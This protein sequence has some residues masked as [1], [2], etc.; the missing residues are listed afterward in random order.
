M[1]GEREEQWEKVREQIE[2][3]ICLELLKDPKTLPCLHTYCKECLKKSVTIVQDKTIINC[4]ACRKEITL[5]DKGVE[6]LPTNFTLASLVEVV[7]LHEKVTQSADDIKCGSCSNTSNS[8]VVAFCY[9]CREF[10]CQ[11]CNRSHKNMKTL[12]HHNCVSVEELKSLKSSGSLEKPEFCK[13]HPEKKVKLYC[14]ACQLL[15]CKDCALV[16]HKDHTYD[17][18]NTVADNERKDLTAA[19]YSLEVKLKTVSDKITVVSEERNRLL[20]RSESDAAKL[21]DS[22]E[23]AITLLTVR[24]EALDADIKRDCLAVVEPVEVYEQ[25]LKDTEVQMKECVKFGQELVKQPSNQEMLGMKLQVME[26]IT[27]LNASYQKFLHDQPFPQ[28][29]PLEIRNLKLP[30]KDVI[31]KFCSSYGEFKILNN[32]DNCLLNGLGIVRAYKSKEAYFSITLKNSED[33]RLT[34]YPV[35]HIVIQLSC[36]TDNSVIDCQVTD[37]KDGLFN[38][39]YTPVNTGKHQIM[40]TIEGN[41]FP[42]SPFEVNVLPPYA[43]IG[44]KCREV[45]EFGEGRKFGELCRVAVSSS[46]DIAVSDSTNKCII[47]LN[48]AYHFKCVISGKDENQLRYPL[49][50]VYT[51]KDTLLVVDGYYSKIKEFETGGELLSSFGSRGS[52]DGQLVKPSGIAIDKNNRVYIVDR[53]NSRV[54][55]FADGMFQTK[56]GT[57]GSGKGQFEEPYDIAIDNIAEQIFVTDRKLDRVQGFNLQGNFI[58]C[59]SNR[60]ELGTMRCPNCITIDVD[61]FVLITECSRDKQDRYHRIS[62]YSPQLGQ[63]VTSLGDK[64]ESNY[65]LDWPFGIA[66]ANNGDVIVVEYEGRCI[67]IFEL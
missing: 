50:I 67:K 7:N 8:K 47:I 20:T 58:S 35:S 5:D 21:R 62:I 38:V 66:V 13:E 43:T 42:G 24:K 39:S 52:E 51:N 44:L 4:P 36:L 6:K 29:P 40:I 19:L 56:F 17:F 59:Y 41:T 37:L 2:C 65:Q 53:G 27:E 12:Q 57:K 22:I 18:I 34:S 30:D 48:R 46:G 55:S 63:F 61:S 16:K 60:G 45:R 32:L 23:Q 14:L 54:Q 28:K 15:I 25:T 31:E 9:N 11:D 49:G 3:A 1:S 10:L 26:R 33:K 64:G